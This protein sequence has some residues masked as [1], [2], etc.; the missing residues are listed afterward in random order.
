MPVESAKNDDSEIGISFISTPSPSLP[1]LPGHPA[2]D[3]RQ[4]AHRHHFLPNIADMSQLPLIR[5]ELHVRLPDSVWS[6]TGVSSRLVAGKEGVMS[7]PGA[8]SVGDRVSITI[9]RSEAGMGE[10]STGDG[11]IVIWEGG[12]EYGV[13]AGPCSCGGRAVMSLYDRGEGVV[14]TGGERGLAGEGVMAAG[15]YGSSDGLGMG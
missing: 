2:E 9:G 15:M 14:G 5:A 10:E 8:G 1:H 7:C 13:C 11:V 6:G 3:V 4:L 12:T